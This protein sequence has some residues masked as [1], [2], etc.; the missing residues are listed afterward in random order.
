MTAGRPALRAGGLTV[1]LAVLVVVMAGYTMLAMDL[2]WRTAAGRIGPGF[3]P[4]IVG[5]TAIVLLVV[6]TIQSL[7]P[8][9]EA[10]DEE[11]ESPLGLHPRM[12]LQFIGAGLVFVLVLVP[13]GAI[14]ASALFLGVTLALLDRRRVGRTVA[15]AVALPVGL[16]LLFQVALNAGLPTGILPLR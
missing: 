15:V 13:L 4:R 16:Y 11:D 8:A 7:R 10:A 5:I 1:F 12:L 9:P 2:Q 14:V 6:A 3:F